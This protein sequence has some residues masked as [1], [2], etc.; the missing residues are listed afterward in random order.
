MRN[1]QEESGRALCAAGVELD[2]GDRTIFNPQQSR[3]S[4]EVHFPALLLDGRFATVIKLRERYN[5]NTHAVA[6]AIGQKSLPEHIDAV[7]G[8]GFIEFFVQRANQDYAPEA[9]NRAFGL[10]AAAQP[11]EHGDSPELIDVPGAPVG[12]QNIQHGPSDGELVAQRERSELRKGTH[13]VKWRGEHA[14][15]HF[16]APPLGVEEQ[17]AV[18]E[19]DLV[20]GA[21]TPVEV[22]KI[23]AASEGDVLAIVNVLAV[24]QDI[25]SGAAAK[26]G[27]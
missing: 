18:K 11:F 14:G 22:F 2:R 6:G 7:T 8:I 9:I 1:G 20:T 26:K 21:D 25:G 5:R 16:A 13:H 15:L 10:P 4:A 19:F 27:A 23:S 17:Q 3:G 12:L 24:R